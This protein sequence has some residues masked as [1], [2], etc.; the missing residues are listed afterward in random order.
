M[1]HILL[2][3]VTTLMLATTAK[4]QSFQNG[5][6]KSSTAIY[7]NPASSQIS[8]KFDQPSKVS[9]VAIYSIIGNEVLNRKVEQSNS[10]KLNVQ[11]LKKG[12]YIVRVFNTDGTTESLSLI[13]N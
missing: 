13:K 2:L 11:N 7:P 5:A 6:E 4:A 3:I 1:K 9:Y 8:I 10:F 12:K